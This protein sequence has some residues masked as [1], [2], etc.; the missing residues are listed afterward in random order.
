[1]EGVAKKAKR[2]SATN[3]F[4]V[5]GLHREILEERRLVNVIALLVP[6]VNV[7][8]ARRNVVPLRILIGKMAVKFAERFRCE[9]RLHGVPDFAETRPQ[10]AQKDCLS[11]FVFPQRLVYKVNVHSACERERDY[12][13]RRH[14]EVC[15]DMLVHARFEVAV[16]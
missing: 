16:S 12:E 8:G 14:E 13:W 1:R 2:A 10:I 6:L 7:A 5:P 11:V 15:L 3:F 9:R 4:N